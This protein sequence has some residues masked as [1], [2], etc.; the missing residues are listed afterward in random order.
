MISRIEH[1]F[2]LISPPISWMREIIGFLL[3]L[4]SAIYKSFYLEAIGTKINEEADFY[5]KHF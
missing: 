1:Y 5:F 4:E 2:F 3:Y